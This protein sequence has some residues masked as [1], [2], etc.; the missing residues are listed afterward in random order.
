MDDAGSQRAA[1][2]QDPSGDPGATATPVESG[3]AAAGDPGA[4]PESRS[5]AAGDPGANPE[6]RPTA[7]LMHP[8]AVLHDTGWGHPEHQG[9]LRAIASALKEDMVAL[10]GRVVQVEPGTASEE[11]VALAHEDA[12]IGSVREA[13]DQAR[14]LGR[15]MAIEASTSISGASWEAALG[16]V[17]AG[18]EAVHG[19]AQGRY[20][21][22]FVAARPPGHHATP[23]QAMGFC[24]FNNVAV[25]AASLRARNEAERVLVVDWDVHHG[26][27]TQDIFYED[28]DVFFLSLHQYPHYPGTGAANET[29]RGRGEGFTLNVP[30][31]PS[32]PRSDYLRVFRMAL[33]TAV[34]RCE[35]EFVLVSSGFDV[36]AGDPLGGQLLE[37][38][39]LHRTTRMVMEAADR[40][41]RGRVVVFLEGGYA[42]QRTG[43]GCVAVIRALAGVS[44]DV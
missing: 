17:G 8:S 35:P 20:R 21:N 4:N 42:P 7:F 26:N 27:G 11:D 29:G 14:E 2:G 40:C 9:R 43:A 3:S 41:C 39:D 30:L 12:L 25:A 31:S 10:H 33:E 19:V 16:T 36:L 37:P 24:L 28:P 5:A 1:R 32:T 22:A 38:E 15:P 13:A 23:G 6:S 18:L 34:E 44:M